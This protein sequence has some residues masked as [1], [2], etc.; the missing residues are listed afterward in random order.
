MTSPEPLGDALLGTIARL[1]RWA[2]RHAEFDLPPAQ[3]RLMA[4]IDEL[5]PAR[6]G[7]LA[8]ADHCSQPTMSAQV[9]RLE[10]RGWAV[11]TADPADGRASL[12]ALSP[13][14]RETLARVRARRAA[15]V[16][17]LIDQLPDVDRQRLVE[18]IAI[19]QELAAATTAPRSR[20]V[21]KEGL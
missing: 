1:H 10:H 12:I 7:D 3:A 15:V 13:L 11:R 17:P 5:G 19:L 2:S 6:I 21:A 8:D 18:A 16:A 14:G 4:Q 9:A 20:T